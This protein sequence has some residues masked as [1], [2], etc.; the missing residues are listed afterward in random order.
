MSMPGLY[1][2]FKS[3]LTDFLFNELK[4]ARLLFAVLALG[5]AMFAV[6][7][8]NEPMKGYIPHRAINWI[9]SA[10]AFL[11][12]LALFTDKYK[13]LYQQ[14]AYA[15]IYL[16]NLGSVYILYGTSFNEQYAYQFIVAY[17]VSGWFFRHEWL[18]Y[19]HTLI[20][21]A[22]LVITS[23][24]S[25]HATQSS[26]DFYATYLIAAFAQLVLIKYRF[27]LE[28]ELRENGNKYR[29]LAENSR[30]II[31]I[32]E[33]DST[34]A[35]VSP[36]ITRILGY[37]ENEVVGKKLY[38]FVHPDDKI[39]LRT[40]NLAEPEHPSVHDPV[41]YR[42][43]DKNGNYHWLETVFKTVKDEVTGKDKVMTQSRDIRRSK[44][45][46]IQLEERSVELERSNADLETFAFVSSHDMKEPLR[47]IS[48]YMQLLKKRYGD[49]LNKEANEYIDYANRGAVTL[50]RLI[51]D[52]LA[53]SR[54]TRTEIKRE[55][56][57]L[58]KVAGEAIAN[59]ELMVR[60]KNGAVKY[61]TDCRISTDAGLLVLVLQN[62]IENGIKYNNNKH[63]VVELGCI[64][65]EHSVV[66]YV[67]DNGEGIAENHQ[68]RI[69][70][71]FHRLHTKA[72]IPG[73]GLGLSICKRI[74]E[75]LGGRIWVKSALGEGTTFYFSLPA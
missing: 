20:I 56:V 13:H 39:L 35:Y 12:L 26:F 16:I 74:V 4:T 23:L 61:E 38:D 22:A 63:P 15:Y 2:V 64:K 18:Y 14:F 68:Q 59:V 62:L 40:L 65:E 32:H 67:R 42:I 9:D 29:L 72:E 46:Q 28:E 21:N 51:Q 31:C 52:L 47:M 49:T 7:G 36:A 30:D 10:A 24:F 19:L 17:V 27:G 55:E 57:S 34:V 37:S 45:Y 43:L 75:R 48:N 6:F 33:P 73:T 1:K 54:I 71:P 50:Q 41:Q 25:E 60:E 5:F 8:D 66:V 3:L 53:Y 44:G 58:A 11:I 69:F 70:E